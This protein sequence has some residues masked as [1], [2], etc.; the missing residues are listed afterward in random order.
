MVFEN[1]RIRF[2]KLQRLK[3]KNWTEGTEAI[4]VR[5]KQPLTRGSEK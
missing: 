2:D 5:A 4:N 1:V 3:P